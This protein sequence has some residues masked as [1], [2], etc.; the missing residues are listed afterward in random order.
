MLI[1]S[2]LNGYMGVCLLE[3]NMNLQKKILLCEPHLQTVKYIL[4]NEIIPGISNLAVNKDVIGIYQ[5]AAVMSC[6]EGHLD[7]YTDGR[8]G[9]GNTASKR[10]M[11]VRLAC[12]VLPPSR[13]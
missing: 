5:P 4:H 2:W 8:Q 7:L 12:P 9:A 10:G 1:F 3:I 11:Q 13:T 6:G